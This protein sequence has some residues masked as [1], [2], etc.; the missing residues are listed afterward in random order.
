M[1]IILDAP[2]P[3]RTLPPGLMRLQP[4]RP[5][6]AETCL[7]GALARQYDCHAP[8]VLA[9]RLSGQETGYVTRKSSRLEGFG[10]FEAP[11]S[12][13]AYLVGIDLGSGSR[14]MVTRGRCR[15]EHVYTPWSVGV[16]SLDEDHAAHLRT[17]FDFAYIYV[18]RSA[19]ERQAQEQGQRFV[20][21]ADQFGVEDPVLAAIAR[22]L[23]PAIDRPGEVS[24]LFVDSLANAILLH[25]AQRYGDLRPEILWRGGLARWQQRR[26]EELLS[27]VGADASLEHLSSEC[28]LSRGYFAKAFKTTYGITPHKWL[29]KARI[30][31]AKSLLLESE[32][33]VV[34]IAMQCGFVDQSH[35]TRVFSRQV[36]APPARWRR[37]YRA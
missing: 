20:E 21:L 33:S 19:L 36:G 1:P 24:G 28:G 10:Y 7:R 34:D 16:R 9:T 17:A 15:G 23:L 26:A 22:A 29:S 30:E 11:A 12:A 32:L 25:L 14:Q 35:L 3:P 8:T 18:P 37:Q 27:D 2:T 31:R 13:Q 5:D 4:G 6:T